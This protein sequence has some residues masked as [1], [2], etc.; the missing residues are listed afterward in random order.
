MT[1]SGMNAKFFWLVATSEKPAELHKLRER[2]F[3]AP[4]PAPFDESRFV[5]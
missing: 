3:F 5:L 4:N 2:N 1:G